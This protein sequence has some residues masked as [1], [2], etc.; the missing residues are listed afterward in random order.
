MLYFTLFKYIFIRFTSSYL[1]SWL[2][3]ILLFNWDKRGLFFDMMLTKL[4]N[5]IIRSINQD[6]VGDILS[7]KSIIGVFFSLKLI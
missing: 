3:G 6:T 7:K 4:I 2:L 1:Y 5:L